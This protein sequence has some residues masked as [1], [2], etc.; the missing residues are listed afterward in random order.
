MLANGN[1][2]FDMCDI[3]QDPNLASVYEVTN[4][5]QPQVVWQMN[6]KNNFAYRAFRIP[7]MYPGVQW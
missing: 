7:S 5:P 4:A 3:S 2:E 6:I 1:V